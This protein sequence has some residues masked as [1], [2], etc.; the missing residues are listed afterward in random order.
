M[1]NRDATESIRYEIKMTCDEM[2][3]PD[4]RSWVRLH[5]DSFAEAYPP[6]Q[7]NNLYLDTQEADCLN[8]NLI[9]VD[10]RGKLRFRW[11]GKSDRAV[12]GTWELKC[13]AD[14][15]GSKHR[16]PVPF[17]F[18]LA[19]VSWQ[20]WMRQ[21]RTQ[22]D[23]FMAVWLSYVDRPTL[24]N[25]YQREYYES[26]DRQVR[27]TVDYDQE[28]YAQLPY[29][30]PNLTLKTPIESKVVLEVKSAPALYRRVSDVLS[31]LPLQVARN[32]KYVNGVLGSVYF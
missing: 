22:V 10:E 20:E 25:R 5:P 8:A 2:L 24:L 16:Y 23:G 4:V 27:I 15:L 31:S 21:M 7:V 3:L 30:M 28:V 29:P 6:R 1:R 11:Y 19:T 13:K 32:S 26:F 12:Q 17:T 18:D 14:R 9:G